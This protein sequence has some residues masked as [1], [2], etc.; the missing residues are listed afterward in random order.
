MDTWST[1]PLRVTSPVMKVSAE[2]SYT[3]TTMIVIPEVTRA[4]QSTYPTCTLRNL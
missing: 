3:S 1:S 4:L 2:C